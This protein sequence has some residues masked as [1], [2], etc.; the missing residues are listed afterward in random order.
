MDKRD[1]NTPGRMKLVQAHR[2]KSYKEAQD[3]YERAKEIM[4]HLYGVI[5]PSEDAA[6]Y[7]GFHVAQR[8]D[9]NVEH[10]TGCRWEMLAEAARRAA[11][12]EGLKVKG[13]EKVL[14]LVARDSHYKPDC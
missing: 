8:G 10:D 4:V 3:L 2:P 12:G 11:I 9:M 6:L 1:V 13:E 7:Y 5:L 14:T